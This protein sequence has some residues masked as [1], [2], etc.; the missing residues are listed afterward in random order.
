MKPEDLAEGMRLIVEELKRFPTEEELSAVPYWSSLLSEARNIY[1][2]LDPLQVT[3][4]N[5]FRETWVDFPSP[6]QEE[7]VTQIL[8]KRKILFRDSAGSGKTAPAV[9]GKG[10][11]KT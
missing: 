11:L 4:E 1:G 8:E 5:L 2:G 3:M 9:K 10:P 6:E 7:G